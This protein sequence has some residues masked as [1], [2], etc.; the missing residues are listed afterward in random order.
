MTII[1]L[2]TNDLAQDQRMDRICS[3]LVAAGH[4]VTLVGRLL[5]TS[6]ELPDKVYRQHRIRCRY[7]KGKLFYVEYNY[8]L[9]R[10]LRSWRYDAI[11]AVDLDTLLAGVWLTSAEH[12][13]LVFDAHEWFSETPEVVN[14]TVIRGFW[15][16]M[17]KALVPKTDARYTVAPM[18]AGKLSEE[19]GAPFGTVR[20][21]PLR[22]SSAAD[23]RPVTN[24]APAAPPPM[25]AASASHPAHYPLPTTNYPLI[26]QGM[27]NPGRGLVTAL[28]ALADLPDCQL[29][30][31]GDGPE[32]EHLRQCA[33][34][35]GV[36]DRVWFAGFRPPA[37]LPALT[38]QAWLGLNLLD[39]VSPSYYYSLANKAF[40]YIQA[41]LPSVQM[42]FPEY[43]S[44]Q[45]TYGCYALLESLEPSKLVAIVERLIAHPTAYQQLVAASERAAAELVWENEI[46][47]LLEIWESL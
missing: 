38:E 35:F 44:I 25:S 26:Y 47:R 33:R 29:W 9:T 31:I 8:L 12:H 20:N 34:D 1:C 40:D 32:M 15:R 14:R 11:C 3:S 21:L 43:C 42:A 7:H 24:L 46:P 45:D 10:E 41:G 13:K 23:P 4:E 22:R 17:A 6:K 18:L 19:Y 37:E 5:P 2:V 28:A 27:L 30:L 16:G 36:E 39:A